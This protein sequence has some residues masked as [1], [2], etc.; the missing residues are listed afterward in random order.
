MINSNL[1]HV[2]F[3]KNEMMSSLFKTF[4]ALENIGGRFDQKF[5][6]STAETVVIFQ[7]ASCDVTRTKARRK[8]TEWVKSSQLIHSWAE[9]TPTELCYWAA[10]QFT[11]AIPAMGYTLSASA[12]LL[13]A[14]AQ[15]VSVA[16]RDQSWSSGEW[17][18][19]RKDAELMDFSNF[20]F[21]QKLCSLRIYFLLQLISSK[22]I[23]YNT[24]R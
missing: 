9:L 8:S 5:T 24:T 3:F 23:N 2:F 19:N 17:R 20:C 16:S 11:P 6:Q 15:L 7:F 4:V 10:E 12:L 14:H 22:L 13:S 21:F 18:L 1:P